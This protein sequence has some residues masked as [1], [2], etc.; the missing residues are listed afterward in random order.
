MRIENKYMLLFSKET[1]SFLL[2]GNELDRC[3]S[4]LDLRK[5][6]LNKFHGV[7]C[8]YKE[9]NENVSRFLREHGIN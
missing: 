1:E 7:V 3:K 6:K 5:A 9:I 8:T 2:D 4:L